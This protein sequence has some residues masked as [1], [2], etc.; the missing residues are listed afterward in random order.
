MSAFPPKAD[1]AELR[2][3]FR[4]VPKTDSCSAAILSLFDHQVGAAKQ[5]KRHGNTTNRFPLWVNN[6]H[7][8]V[9][10]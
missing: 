8:A 5:R 1:I 9:K 4:F 6:G 2:R 10:S 3:D 7:D